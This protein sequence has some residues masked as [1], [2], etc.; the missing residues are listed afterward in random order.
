[1]L[2]D[3]QIVELYS[4]VLIAATIVFLVLRLVGALWGGGRHRR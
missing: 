3:I 2:L 1:M 4:T